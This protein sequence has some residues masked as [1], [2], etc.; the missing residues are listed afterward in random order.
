ML[1]TNLIVCYS[2]L[3]SNFL[4]IVI[5]SVQYNE[6]LRAFIEKKNSTSLKKYN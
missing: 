4:S 1:E 2:K 5:S 3:I 6:I